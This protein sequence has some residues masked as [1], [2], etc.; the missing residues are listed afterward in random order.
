MGINTLC[1]DSLRLMYSNATALH[2]ENCRDAAP[3]EMMYGHS[4]LNC[5]QA[6]I[7]LAFLSLAVSPRL[8]CG[9]AASPPSCHLSVSHHA[10]GAPWRRCCL[11]LAQ[12]SAAGSS[13]KQPATQMCIMGRMLF[14]KCE[15][16]AACMAPDPFLRAQSDQAS[17]PAYAD[18]DRASGICR[19]PGKHLSW[20]CGQEDVCEL[21]ACC[22]LKRRP[23][24]AKQASPSLHHAH[25][26]ITMPSGPA[27]SS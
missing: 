24:R 4:Q 16:S 2:E 26:L 3:L 11:R 1:T 25:H 14:W 13:A 12:A 9:T 10:G 17:S 23:A 19:N 6:P 22:Q 7:F 18:S 21:T 15:K 27:D 20:T 8:H 5:H